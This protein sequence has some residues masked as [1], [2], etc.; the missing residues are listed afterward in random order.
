MEPIDDPALKWHDIVLKAQSTNPAIQYL[1]DSINE[2]MAK[3]N[4]TKPIYFKNPEKLNGDCQIRGESF[5]I[6]FIG[7]DLYLNE[8]NW[9]WIL[10]EKLR[11]LADHKLTILKYPKL[12]GYATM[13][14]TGYGQKTTEEIHRKDLN[15]F[16]FIMNQFVSLTYIPF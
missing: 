7:R 4:D 15:D 1:Y 3:L 5:E 9:T 12:D 16:N 2:Q 6:I 13:I 10:T 8:D 11:P 14:K